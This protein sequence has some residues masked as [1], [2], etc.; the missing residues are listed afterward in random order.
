MNARTARIVASACVAGLM[1]FSWCTT[2]LAV[3]PGVLVNDTWLDNSRAEPASPVYSE[4]GTDADTD[5]DLESAWFRGGAGTLAPVAAGGPLRGTGYGGSSASWTTYFTP[6]GSEVNLANIGDA[7]QV[8]WNF[9]FTG[10]NATNANRNFRIG[11][12]DS[13]AASRVAADASPG[14]AAYTGYALFLNA[15]QTQ[16]TTSQL[17]ERTGTGAFLSASGEWATVLQASGANGNTGYADAVNYSLVM[18]LTRNAADGL[19]IVG[20]VS[21]GNLDGD[22]SLNFNFTDP[23]PNGFLYDTFGVRPSSDATVATTIDTTLFRVEA[24]P[25]PGTIGL[26]AGFGSLLVLRR[27]R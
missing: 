17:L 25:E 23:T 2:G 3:V 13:P 7:L 26:V 18:T 10:T 15:A 21:G 14:N 6:E 12:V 16:G 27:R 19:D 5:G 1:S 20:T 24:I 4:N 11:L 9:T 8:T 22:G